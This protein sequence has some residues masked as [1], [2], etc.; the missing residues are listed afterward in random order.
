[1]MHTIRH[2]DSVKINTSDYQGEDRR[3]KGREVSVE[4]GG[5]KMTYD[6]NSQESRRLVDETL[7]NMRMATLKDAA[8]A[9]FS[10]AAAIVITAAAIKGLSNTPYSKP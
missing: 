10:M 1:M 3:K 9:I 4:A 7:L 6:A 8:G 2:P 5:Y